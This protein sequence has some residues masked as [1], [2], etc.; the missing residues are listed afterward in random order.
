MQPCLGIFSELKAK[1]GPPSSNLKSLLPGASG[2]P[3]QLNR[4][5]K[6]RLLSPRPPP[7]PQPLRKCSEVNEKEGAEEVQL[8]ERGIHGA[9]GLGD[10]GKKPQGLTAHVGPLPAAQSPP[11]T[12]VHGELFPETGHK[13]RCHWIC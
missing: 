6:S 13:K 12:H 11:W 4:P 2:P 9:V 7:P 3:V 5:E 10:T 8:S 1:M